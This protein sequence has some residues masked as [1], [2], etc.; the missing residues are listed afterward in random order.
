MKTV[1]KWFDLNGEVCVE[2]LL[3][4]TFLGVMVYSIL[5]IV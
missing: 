1:Q 4:T 2:C 5:T 3:V